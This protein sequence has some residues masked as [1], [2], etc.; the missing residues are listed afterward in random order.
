MSSSSYMFANVPSNT[1]SL[2]AAYEAWLKARSPQQ[3]A[4]KIPPSLNKRVGIVGAG[5]AGLYAALLLKNRGIDCRLFEAHPERLGG[6]VYTHRFNQEPNQY[7]EAGAMRLPQTPEQQPVFDLIHYLNEQIPP[8]SKIDLIPYNL[9]DPNGNLVYVNGKRAFGGST[10]T[11][12]YANEHPESLGF[13][14]PPED[15]NKT[16]SQ[17]LDEVLQPFFDLLAINFDLGFAKIVQYDNYSLY[18]Y[19][20]EIEGWSMEKVNYVEV[21]NSASNQFQSS[22]TEMVIESMDFSGAKWSTIANGMDRLPNACAALIG[23]ESITMNAPVR[24]VENLQDGRIAVHYGDLGEFDT[25]DSVIL[26]LPPAALRMIATPQWSPTKTQAIRSMHFEP[27]Y[28][29]GLRFKTRFWEQLPQAAMGGQSSSDLPMRW[30]VY[31]SYGLGDSGAG[32]LLLYSWMTDAYNWLPQNP[33]ERVRLALRDLQT[34]YQN[35]VDIHEQFIESFDVAWPSEWATGDA[36]FYPGQFRQLFNSARQAEQN[37]YFAGEHLSVHHTW[38]V[39]ALDS[40][41]FAC[42]QL[43]GDETLEP[44]RSPTQTPLHPHQHDYSQCAAAPILP[45]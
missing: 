26:A 39:G 41:L 3:P 22:F 25:F 44:L 7:F 42:Q 33:E 13:N 28:K 21:M 12:N 14:L 43:L 11:L 32:V 27:L 16:A 9:Y 35:T 37:I 10:M 29:I 34:L 40:A 8:E 2:R 24:Q 17:L 31:P 6:R 36:M 15:R 4:Q 5:M 23:E 38:I 18:T 19:L 30:C 20:T 45:R 1:G